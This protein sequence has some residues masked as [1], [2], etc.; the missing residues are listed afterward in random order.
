[1]QWD[2]LDFLNHT[3]HYVNPTF[4]QTCERTLNQDTYRHAWTANATKM[5]PLNQWVHYTRYQYQT[6][7]ETLSQ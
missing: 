2:T 3:D 1:M 6:S 5:S 7:E 4:G